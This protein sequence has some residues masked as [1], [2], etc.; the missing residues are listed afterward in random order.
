MSERGEAPPRSGA[1][2]G[3][4]S[5]LPSASVA[6][7]AGVLVVLLL[8]PLFALLT[9]VPPM[10]ILRA[11]GSP[12]VEV[13]L[14]FTVLASLLALAGSVVFGLPLGYVLARRRFPGREVIESI[15]LLPLVLPHL[16]A[17]LALLMVFGPDAP[18]GRFLAT[19]GIPVWDTI[20]GVV[21]VMGYVS[22]SYVVS[23]SMTAFRAVDPEMVGV[24]RTLGAS[25]GDVFLQITLPLSL[26]GILGGMGLSW[27]RS[28]SEIGGLLV[29]GYTVYPWPAGANQPVWNPI[30]VLIFETYQISPPQALAMAA[31]LLLFAL[32][33]FLGM[34]VLEWAL[35]ARGAPRE[36]RA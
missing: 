15:V 10:A 5:I 12:A 17:G 24:A 14:G 36:S 8:L 11:A 9:S 29:L 21:A 35:R 23:A 3:W 30:S 4:A 26:R 27:A 28:L 1:I 18:L 7:L 22:T 20:W 33:A 19:L 2:G 32:S 31:L 16:I 25:R 34:R 6:G 13:S